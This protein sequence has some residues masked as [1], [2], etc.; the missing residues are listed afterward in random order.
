MVAHPRI[1][2]F[3]NAYLKRGDA[4]TRRSLSTNR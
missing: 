3:V 2:G 4:S 1:L